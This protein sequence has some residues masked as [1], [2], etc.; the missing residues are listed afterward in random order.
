M[1]EEL[2]LAAYRERARGEFA[3]R[4]EMASPGLTVVW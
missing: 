3:G 1:W 2:D 4:I